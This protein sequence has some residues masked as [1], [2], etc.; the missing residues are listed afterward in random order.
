MRPNEKP[1]SKYWKSFWDRHVKTV[2]DNPFR[3]VGRTLNK[4]PMS[5]AM[6]RKFTAHTIDKLELDTDHSVL[7]LCCGNGLFSTEMAGRCQSVVGVDFSCKLIADM[8]SRAPE[9]V[10]GM[11]AD[12]C[13]IKFRPESFHRILFAAAIQHF[14]Q[15]QVIRLFNELASWLK[16]EGLLLVAD[17][18]DARRIWNFYD[19]QE[20]E[21]IYFRNTAAGTPVLGTWLDRV[22]LEKLARYAGFS[23]TQAYDQPD[24]Y[25][26]AHYRFDLVCRK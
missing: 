11:V 24:D 12:V 3:Q 16:P 25:W 9:N 19:S 13:E 5:E 7:D 22:W 17:I 23:H 4:E 18:C 10:V 20:R 15:P 1:V 2:D 14:S 8:A 21:A 6:F 26:Y